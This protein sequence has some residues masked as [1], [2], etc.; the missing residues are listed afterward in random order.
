MAKVKGLIKGY[1]T[2]KESQNGHKKKTPGKV[3]FTKKFK[4]L[5]SKVTKA[6]RPRR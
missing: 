5:K 3:S 4:K 1:S 2:Y 6:R